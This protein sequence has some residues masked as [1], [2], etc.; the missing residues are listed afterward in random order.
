MPIFLN[1]FCC[2]SRRLGY[3]FGNINRLI[4]FA[5]ANLMADLQFEVFILLALTYFQIEKYVI[6]KSGVCL[7]VL[8]SCGI[9]FSL[10]C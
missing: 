5:G 8:T 4:A 2:I 9:F 7:S 1:Y 3:E 10:F 6:R